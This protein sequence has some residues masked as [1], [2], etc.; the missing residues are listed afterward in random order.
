MIFLAVLNVSQRLKQ[1]NILKF[2]QILTKFSF[3]NKWWSEL[4]D[5]A[6]LIPT[7]DALDNDTFNKIMDLSNT[8]VVI[9]LKSLIL[10]SK[11]KTQDF[12]NNQLLD[13][14]LDGNKLVVNVFWPVSNNLLIDLLLCSS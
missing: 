6:F 9:L 5:K 1:L 12:I 13:T 10:K 7:D 4:N 8:D 2:T 3:I 11:Y 14:L